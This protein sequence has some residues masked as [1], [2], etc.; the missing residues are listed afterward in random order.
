MS[1]NDI[2]GNERIKGILRRSLGNDRVPNS[3]LFYGPKGVGKREI[4]LELA[5]S[6]NCEKKEDACGQC[7]SCQSIDKGNNPDVMMIKP[8]NDKIKIEQMREL[9]KIAYLKPMQKGKK[10]FIVNEA[11]NMN[12]EAANSLLKLLEEPPFYSYI[13]LVT[14]NI[15]LIVPT[16]QSRCQLLGF[17]PI[18]RED[19]EKELL[20]KGYETEKAKVLALLARGNLKKALDM[21]WDEI[22]NKRKQAWMLLISIVN[23][24]RV[25]PWIKNYTFKRRNSIKEDIEQM[26]EILSS[27]CRDLI[28]LKERGDVYLLMNPDYKEHIKKEEEKLDINQSLDWLRKIDYTISGLNRNL[29]TNLLVSSFLSYFLGSKHV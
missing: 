28:L 2:I 7:R 11:E 29:N 16:I 13:I 15:F 25:S 3:L 8:E 22:S 6:I 21:E 20:K 10:V 12:E 17:S 9:K 24:E 26:M 5:K 19:I 18:S 1:F 4:A 14:S 27:F 23:K